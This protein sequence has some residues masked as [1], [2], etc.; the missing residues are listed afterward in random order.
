MEQVMSGQEAIVMS[1]G[2]VCRVCREVEG[3]PGRGLTAIC[4]QT[5]DGLRACSPGAEQG[6]AGALGVGFSLIHHHRSSRD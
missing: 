2:S 4:G 5:L 6:S 3:Q 1:D